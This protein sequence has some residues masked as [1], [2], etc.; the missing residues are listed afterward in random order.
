E[1]AE[2]RRGL[3]ERVHLVRLVAAGVEGG[4]RERTAHVLHHDVRDR[5]ALDHAAT[6][7]LRLDADAVVG[8][9]ENAV[10][11]GDVADPTGHLAADRHPAVAVVHDAVGDGDVL[12][13]ASHAAARLVGAALE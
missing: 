10:G 4:D 1:V 11:D 8:A 12:V 2:P 3:V 6:A 9:V 7:A 13:G 5:D